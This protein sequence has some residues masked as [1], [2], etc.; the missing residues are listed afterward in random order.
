M[1]RQDEKSPQAWFV[2]HEGLVTG[3]LTGARIRQLLLEGGLGLSDEVSLDKRK[4]QK[5]AEVPSV[6][7]LQLR[8]DSGD[9]EAMAKVAAREKIRAKD[10]A[11]EHKVPVVPLFVSLLVV[12]LTLAVSLMV[13][14]P[15]KEDTPQCDTP[16]APG[17]NWRNCLLPEL[18]VGAASL[19]G[20]NLNNAVLRQAKLSATDLSAA[21]LGY[22]DLRR[23]D[24][25]YARLSGASLLGANLQN[26]DLRDADLRQADLRF[27][28]LT[29]S[30]LDAALLQGARLDSAIWINGNTCGS[31]SV[32]GCRPE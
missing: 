25:R 23:A 26:A 10:R 12:G 21:D 4:W 17:V 18:D 32:G 19:A 31:N 5:I 29:G 20:A 7:P 30:R 6:V 13:G 24:L 15:G 16:P 8:A 27:A 11:R 1:K 14:G 2:S 9:K 28:D 22:A 3:P